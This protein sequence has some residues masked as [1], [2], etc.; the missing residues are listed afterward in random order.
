MPVTFSVLRFPRRV[1]KLLG[2]VVVAALI[3]YTISLVFV[4]VTSMQDQREP[5]DAIV[6]LGAAQYNGRPSPVLRRTVQ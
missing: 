4:L 3:A 1:A 5:V 6:V 2:L